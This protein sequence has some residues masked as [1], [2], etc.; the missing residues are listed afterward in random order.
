M[1]ITFVIGKKLRGFI[2]YCKP[3]FTIAIL[4]LLTAVLCAMRIYTIV[5]YIIPIR[6]FL[7]LMAHILFLE[8][9]LFVYNIYKIA[10]EYIENHI[11]R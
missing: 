7:F 4:S 1:F 10:L 8:P 11:F 6:L 3:S 5:L 9:N 2:F